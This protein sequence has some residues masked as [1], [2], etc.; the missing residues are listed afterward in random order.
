MKQKSTSL[1]RQD[2]LKILGYSTLGLGLETILSAC[3]PQT[4]VP[5]PT[6]TATATQILTPIFNPTTA[7]TQTNTPTAAPTLNPE[8]AAAAARESRRLSLIEK[9]GPATRALPLEFHGDYYYMLD[10]MYNMD[11]ETF[12]WMMEWFQANDVWSVNGAELAGFLD[13]TME[14]P[15]RC[16]VLTTDSGYTSQESLTRMIPVLQHTEMHF[17][18]LIWTARMTAAETIACQEDAC[19]EKFRQARDSG[20]FTLGTHSESH[21]DFKKMDAAPGLE[22]LLQSKEE[23]E[24]NLGVEVEYLSWP[25][26]HCPTWADQLGDLGFKAAFGGR[27][28]ALDLCSVFAEDEMRWCLPRLLPPNRGTRQSSRPEGMTLE[29]MMRAYSDGFEE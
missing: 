8:Q 2:F 20:V 1:S 9:Y 5:A 29:E 3:S 24:T 12:T 4:L 21:A 17:I 28:R 22:E 18:S 6:S 15:A 14:L 11:P 19:W 7:P 27:P 10:G 26:E 16:V 25:Y 13:G 23:I